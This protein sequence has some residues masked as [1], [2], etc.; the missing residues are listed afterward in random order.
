MSEFQY[1]EFQKIDGQLS[2]QEILEVKKLSSRAKVN[3]NQAVFIYSY[4]DFRGEPEEILASHFDAMLYL[5]NWGSKQLSFR[6]PRHLISIKDLRIYE[7]DDIVVIKEIN[8][9]IILNLYFDNEEGSGWVEED[10]IS[11]ILSNL[12]G[13]RRDILMNDYS[14]L[15]LAWLAHLSFDDP[16]FLNLPVP[17]NLQKLSPE[18]SAFVDFFE[19]CPAALQIVSLK[20][21]SVKVPKLDINS[22][23]DEEMRYF[24]KKITEGSPLVEVELNQR[25]QKT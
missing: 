24:L 13:L 16:E 9:S 12:S 7:H 2:A 20:S 21:K 8:D 15:Y 23:S 4:G 3:R 5:A 10:E 1:Y 14:C 17:A 18:L 11:A 19:V 22:L 25:L 6:L